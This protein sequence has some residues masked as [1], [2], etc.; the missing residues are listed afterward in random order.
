MG[1]IRASIPQSPLTATKKS[2]EGLEC[3]SRLYILEP[4][5]ACKVPLGPPVSPPGVIPSWVP[6]SLGAHRDRGGLQQH[7]Y[8]ILYL[9]GSFPW[10]HRA[11]N[12][13][14]IGVVM[15]HEL[16]HAFDDQGESPQTVLA[17]TP[18]TFL[19]PPAPALGMG[20]RCPGCTGIPLCH[21][22]HHVCS[23]PPGHPLLSSCLPRWHLPTP[24]PGFSVQLSLH[25]LGEDTVSA[26]PAPFS[27]PSLQ[28]RGWLPLASTL[29]CT[30]TAAPEPTRGQ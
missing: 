16:T 25:P 20:K 12:F 5:T 28:G 19:S 29:L 30:L 3:P 4:R 23:C 24:P 18:V 21:P 17:P 22:L 9:P 10:P 13:G 2:P 8:H 1:W 14:G 26:A 7:N 6:V 15:G 11:L 27:S